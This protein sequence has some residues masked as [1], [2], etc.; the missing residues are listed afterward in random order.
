MADFRVPLAKRGEPKGGGCKY[1]LCSSDWH[2]ARLMREHPKNSAQFAE[3]SAG[4]LVRRRILSWGERYA[5]ATV[6]ILVPRAWIRTVCAGGV[7]Q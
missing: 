1:K 7:E 5:N 6:C 4:I 2:K 3:A